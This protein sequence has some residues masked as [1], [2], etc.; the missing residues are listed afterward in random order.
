MEDE[1][2]KRIFLIGLFAAG[3]AALSPEVYAEV[4]HGE[5]AGVELETRTLLINKSVPTRTA[6]PEIVRIRVQ[7]D[8]QFEG[9]AFGE[10]RPGDE[11]SAEVFKDEKDGAWAAKTIQLNKVNIEN[12]NEIVRDV[13]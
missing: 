11:V 4:F 3:C 10:L 12:G 13:L 2:K 8:T 7:A 9:A 1:M 5:I 6:K